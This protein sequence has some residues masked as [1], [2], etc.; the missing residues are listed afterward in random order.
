M[1]TEDDEEIALMR[2]FQSCGAITE[3]TFSLIA[4]CQ[5]SEDRGTRNRASKDDYKGQG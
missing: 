1:A 4:T 2:E 3:K 5:N